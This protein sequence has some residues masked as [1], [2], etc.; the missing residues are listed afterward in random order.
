MIDPYM[1]ITADIRIAEYKGTDGQ[2][3]IKTVALLY[4]CMVYVHPSSS[5]GAIY[6]YGHV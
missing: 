4:G 5:T 2:Y 1:F 3:K 6:V